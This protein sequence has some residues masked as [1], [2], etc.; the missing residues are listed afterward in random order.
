[1][2]LV[3]YQYFPSS[4][5][6]DQKKKNK[7]RLQKTYILAESIFIAFSNKLTSIPDKGLPWLIMIYC[8]Y[9]RRLA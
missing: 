4:Y 5:A 7:P 6:I 9:T 2:I 1:M 8:S 3:N